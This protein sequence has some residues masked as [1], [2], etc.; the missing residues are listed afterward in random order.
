[1]VLPD[2]SARLRVP[3]AELR[4]EYARSSGPGGQNVNKV[5]SK[6]RLRWDMAVSSAIEADA[7]ERLRSLFPGNV[8]SGGEVL[9][10]SDR[11]R[12]RERNRDAAIARLATMIA[13][14]CKRPVVRRATRPSL[15]AKKRRVEGKVSR[16]RTKSMRGRVT[17]YD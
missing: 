2:H 8:T 7:K 13:T 15:G 10:E 1:M 6:V 4:F 16:G 11:Y 17:N 14:A 12:S 9:I 3:Y 5:E